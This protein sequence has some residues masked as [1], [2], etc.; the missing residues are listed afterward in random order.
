LTPVKC[1][2]SGSRGVA[3]LTVMFIM[4][5]LTTLVVYMVEDEHLAIRRVSNQQEAEQAFQTAVYAEQWA[6]RVLDEDRRDNDTDHPGEVWSSEAPAP[7]A[8]GQGSLTVA[9]ADLQGRFNLNNLAPGRDEVWY[10]FFQRLLAV[11]EL[12]PGLADAV[13]DWLDPDINVSGH[14]GA[15]DAEYMLKTPAYRA[16]NRPLAHVD[17][18]AWVQGMTGEAL[19]A[20]RPHVAA[21]PAASVPVNVNTASP[22]LIRALGPDILDAGSAESLVAGR[23]EEGYASVNGFLTR[24]ELAGL[25]DDIE[26]L[27]SVDSGFFEVH[28]Q[29]ELG[30]YGTVLYSVIQRED[31]AGPPRVIQ[32]R[33]G[34]S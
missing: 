14:N 24:S 7:D 17:E 32:R 27:I 11:L 16:A 26:P 30:R 15:E 4:M 22:E 6:R 33:R 20:L 1:P 5:L 2:G 29:V 28:A 8:A 9:V 12:D 23:G 10:P 21:L 13:V 19:R 18:L 34:L 31:G 25:G 3:L